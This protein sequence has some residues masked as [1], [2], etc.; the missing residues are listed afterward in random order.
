VAGKLKFMCFD[1]T[2][3]LTH[4]GL[5]LKGVRPANAGHFDDLFA[6]WVTF[7]LRMII[8]RVIDVSDS[9][10][11]SREYRFLQP[12]LVMVMVL[13]PSRHALGLIICMH[14]AKTSTRTFANPSSPFQARGPAGLATPAG[15][16][17][18]VLSKFGGVRVPLDWRRI[19]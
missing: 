1:K 9:H 6:S 10:H 14:A 16:N 15:G 5:D 12:A 2:G 7:V 17:V 13:I 3:T 19:G 11:K 8:Y 4:D 18:G